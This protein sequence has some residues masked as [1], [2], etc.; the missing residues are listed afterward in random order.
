MED[1]ASVIK[2]VDQ[3]NDTEIDFKEFKT[4]LEKFIEILEWK[5]IYFNQKISL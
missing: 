1:W 2:S 3:N 4:A 5:W